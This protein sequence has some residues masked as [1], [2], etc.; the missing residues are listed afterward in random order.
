[1]MLIKAE[2]FKRASNT[3][4]RKLLLPVFVFQPCT[5]PPQ[6]F[7]SDLSHKF[8]SVLCLAFSTSTFTLCCMSLYSCLLVSLLS[9]SNFFFVNFFPLKSLLKPKSQQPFTDGH[10]LF[11]SRKWTNM[12]Q[13]ANMKF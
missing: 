5:D 7:V 3:D 6:S 12:Y 1:M 4:V 2:E 10:G 9:L 13:V 11:A 8:S